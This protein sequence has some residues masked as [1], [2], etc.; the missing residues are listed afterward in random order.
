MITEFIGSVSGVL[1]CDSI[2]LVELAP[3]AGVL[4]KADIDKYLPTNSQLFSRSIR[5]TRS[6]S[7]TFVAII[8]QS[9]EI[10][11]S[12]VIYYDPAGVPVGFTNLTQVIDTKKY[13][14]GTIE[15]SLEFTIRNEHRE[16]SV[17]VSY[18]K[19]LEETR[20]FQAHRDATSLSYSRYRVM[21]NIDLTAPK[22]PERPRYVGS[23]DIRSVYRSDNRL[24]RY[25]GKLSV[26]GRRLLPTL[27]NIEGIEPTSIVFMEAVPKL[28][29]EDNGPFLL[30]STGAKELIV[31]DTAGN[32]V[33]H[34]IETLSVGH[35]GS[36][37]IL[38]P[39]QEVEDQNKEKYLSYRVFPFQDLIPNATSNAEALQ[40]VN[41]TGEQYQS[42]SISSLL[43]TDPKVVKDP[44]SKELMV[45]FLNRQTQEIQTPSRKLRDILRAF[46]VTDLEGYDIAF[47]SEGLLFLMKYSENQI[48]GEPELVGVRWYSFAGRMQIDGNTNEE[49]F[50]VMAGSTFR[51]YTFLTRDLIY[52]FK[53]GKKDI[54]FRAENPIRI[55]GE[56]VRTNLP[57]IINEPDP[58]VYYFNVY[59]QKK[60]QRGNQYLLER[61]YRDGKYTP[62]IYPL[63]G[64]S[65]MDGY[66]KLLRDTNFDPRGVTLM[67]LSL[68]GRLMYSK[69][70]SKVPG[71]ESFTIGE[72]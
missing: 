48:S 31:A 16:L 42:H 25:S 38:S 61:S 9:Q 20:L 11:I 52:L 7:N 40:T 15:V 60:S 49:L 46:K 3:G 28:T 37:M 66:D 41:V 67:S 4:S 2:A 50:Q 18:D 59:D 12:Y 33:T 10:M 69:V 63:C 17:Q 32:T 22:K 29:R 43:V 44:F 5:V 58:W 39:F 30:M 8:D 71:E 57:A 21:R 68:G 26:G 45:Y 70:T 1:S 36:G 19:H 13:K 65:G 54:D 35:L 62:R 55:D 6:K 51:D 72:L 27:W 14:I 53:S 24:I 34:K 64:D 47:A 23:R 56:A